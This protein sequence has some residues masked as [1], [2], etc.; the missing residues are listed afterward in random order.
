MEA[1]GRLT[2]LCRK[3]I[4]YTLELRLWGGGGELGLRTTGSP[5]GKSPRLGVQE[6]LFLSC[7]RDGWA[8]GWMGRS[9][10]EP[11]LGTG[12]NQMLWMF[13]KNLQIGLKIH[14]PLGPSGHVLHLF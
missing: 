6:V 5:C 10:H 7:L 8:G 14:R 3:L 12:P 9:T 1:G 4:F 11:T 2:R 13:E